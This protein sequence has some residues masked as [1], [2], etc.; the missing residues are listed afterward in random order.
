MGELRHSWGSSGRDSVLTPYGTPPLN[1]TEGK[2]RQRHAYMRKMRDVLTCVDLPQLHEAGWRIWGAFDMLVMGVRDRNQLVSHDMDAQS[3]ALVD[4]LLDLVTR[5]HD[6][7]ERELKYGRRSSP[8]SSPA[9]G[10]QHG[11]AWQAPAVTEQ[12]QQVI[13]LLGFLASSTCADPD[14]PHSDEPLL[15]VSQVRIYLVPLLEYLLAVDPLG[16][17]FDRLVAGERDEVVILAQTGDSPSTEESAAVGALVEAAVAADELG[18]EGRLSRRRDLEGK[19][20]EGR[21]LLGPLKLA[22]FKLALQ[23]Y[24]RSSASVR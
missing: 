9:G 16:A 21:R 13:E 18:A 15:D 5:P 3:A 14:A 4:H 8:G 20:S 24:E 10:S 2:G 1:V 23:A 7:I 12:M 6:E 19:T 11:A 22:V 17:A